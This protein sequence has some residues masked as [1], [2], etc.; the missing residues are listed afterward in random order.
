METT[1]LLKWL[2]VLGRIAGIVGLPLAAGYGVGKFVNASI[3]ANTTPPV[4]TASKVLAGAAAGAAVGAALAAPLFGI[5]AGA[6]AAI[7]ALCGAVGA[8]LS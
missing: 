3:P 1:E 5:G 7:G 2:R 6:G 4:R 8:W